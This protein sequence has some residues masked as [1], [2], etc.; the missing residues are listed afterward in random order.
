METLDLVDVITVVSF[1]VSPNNKLMF[2]IFD[3][4]I[5]IENHIGRF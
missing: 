2:Q 1:G 3:N 5:F 4:I